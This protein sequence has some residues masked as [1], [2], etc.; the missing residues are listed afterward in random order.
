[1]K[2]EPIRPTYDKIQKEAYVNIVI[3]LHVSF[4]TQDLLKNERLLPAQ[5]E[6]CCMEN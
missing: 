4:Q 3:K 6:P 1:V 2:A 5:Q